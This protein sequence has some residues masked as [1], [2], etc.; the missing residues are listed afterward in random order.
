[1]FYVY[2]LFSHKDKKLYTG[3]ST[4]LKSRI[5]KHQKGFVKATKNRR[6]IELIYYEA[7]ADEID[8]R[9]REIYLKG[10]NGKASMKI[11]LKEILNKL[12]YKHII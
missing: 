5:D 8:A 11:Q 1:M 6:P 10:G 4:N 9:R 12:D 2:I 3:F 7:F